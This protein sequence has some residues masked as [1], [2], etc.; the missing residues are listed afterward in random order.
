MS[1]KSE[2][3]ST[4]KNPAKYFLEWKS[5]DKTFVYY[6]KEK[7]ESVKLDLPL[8]FLTLA[9]MHTVKGWNDSSQSGVFSNEVKFIGT[10]ELN[11][12]SFKGGDIVKGFYKDV[13]TEIKAAGG[14]YTKSVYVL[15][16]EDIW[17]L[18]LKGS[19]VQVWNDFTQKTRAKLPNEWVT[20]SGADER[21]KGSIKYSVPVFE[22]EKALTAKD[23]KTADAAYETLSGYL[24]SYTEK[25]KSPEL[26]LEVEEEMLF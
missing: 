22:F 2:F 4:S 18:Q 13:K 1:R 6:D 15:V 14:H 26:D 21:K 11:V 9:Q 7:G 16:G 3:A 5:N 8:K 24:K 12:R 20:V 10:E 19:A 25:E 23:E 17:N